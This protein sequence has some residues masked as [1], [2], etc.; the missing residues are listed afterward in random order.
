MSNTDTSS[1]MPSVRSLVALAFF[2]T[3]AVVVA[4]VLFLATPEAT[5]PNV[6]HALSNYMP[7]I[8]AAVPATLVT[9]GFRNRMDA[10]D[11]QLATI[12]SNTNGVLDAR[13][14]SATKQALIEHGVIP[15]APLVP[16]STVVVTPV[17]PAENNSADTGNGLDTS[18]IGSASLSSDAENG[19]A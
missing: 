16:A 11:A 13:I 15:A 5:R 9:L 2:V 4:V 17:D 6:W 8:I 1:N 14:K 18:P 3:L 10:Q 7:L 12:T 19:S